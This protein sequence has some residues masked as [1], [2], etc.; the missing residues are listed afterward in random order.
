MT[1]TVGTSHPDRR[2]VAEICPLL[3]KASA[4]SPMLFPLHP[5]RLLQ[6]F[7]GSR[8]AARLAPSH[9]HRLRHGGASMDAVDQHT[10]LSIMAR[11]NWKSARP[12]EL[13]VGLVATS[14]W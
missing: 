4:F 13:I 2:W 11:G 1:G 3:A 5:R 6:L 12:C 14:A 8:R 7:H 10:D 9:P